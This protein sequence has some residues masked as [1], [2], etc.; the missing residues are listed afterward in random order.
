MQALNH[1]RQEILAERGSVAAQPW[2]RLRGLI[3]RT[4]LRESEGLLL[5]GTKAIHTM[6]MRFA[7]DV[8]FLDEDGRALHLLHAFKPSQ[9]SPLVGRSAMVLE[10]PAGTLDRTKTKV[11]DWIEVSLLN[12][13]MATQ[14]DRSTNRDEGA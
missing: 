11:G 3:G 7:I 14:A 8:V 5:L 1:T 12:R 13:A 9:I 4:S 6:G 2:A 10:L